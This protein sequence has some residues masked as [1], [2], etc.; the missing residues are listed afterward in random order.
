VI[1]KNIMV[2]VLSGMTLS[3][4]SSPSRADQP[5]LGQGNVL[6]R[7][8]SDNRRSDAPGIE[9]RTAWMLGFLTAYSQY[10]AT[11][12]V[13]VSRGKTTEQLAE[14]IDQYCGEHP[15]DTLHKASTAMIDAFRKEA[16]Q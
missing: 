7:A 1:R 14:W 10:G 16:K 6:C 4:L 3:L 13:D 9:P 2:V 5:V 8:W 12:A 11:P 15:N